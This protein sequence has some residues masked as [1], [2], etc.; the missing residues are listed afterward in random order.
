MYTGGT[1]V[2][3]PAGEALESMFLSS[4]PRDIFNFYRQFETLEQLFGWM[5]DRPAAP[6]RIVEEEPRNEL[7]QD[8]VVVIPTTNTEG[9]ESDNCRKNVFRG[10]RIIYVESGG[11]HFN[12]CRSV[13]QG[14]RRALRYN[15]QWIV[16]SAD[17][18]VHADSPERLVGE[19]SGREPEGY[20]ALYAHPPAFYHSY[21]GTFGRESRLGQLFRSLA[22]Y[23]NVDGYRVLS[24]FGAHSWLHIPDY[25]ALF[26]NPESGYTEGT[27]RS[28]PL[29]LPG[30]LRMYRHLM[31]QRFSLVEIRSFAILSGCFASEVDGMI[32]DETY[33]NSAGDIDLSVRLAKRNRLGHVRYRVKFLIGHSL[34]I[35]RARKLRDFAGDMLLDYKLKNGSI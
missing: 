2:L 10:L 21:P 6:M 34:G 28:R 30:I 1:S 4:R 31:H 13:N 25:H 3:K 9:P 18:V 29:I 17:D 33:G 5:K 12:V 19:L 26:D 11:P 16:I 24:R 27:E 8:L 20:D 35:D 7:T 22:Q 14:V 32:F 23:R 15:P